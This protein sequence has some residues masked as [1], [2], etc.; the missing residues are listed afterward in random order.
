MARKVEPTES[1]VRAAEAA[2]EEVKEGAEEPLTEDPHDDRTREQTHLSFTRMR[3]DWHGADAG[4]M[5]QIRSQ[6]DHR[7]LVNFGDAYKILND[8][9]EVVRERDC[10]EE[11]GEILVD[12]HNFPVWKRSESGRFIEDYSRLGIKQREEFL[13][14]I[15]TRLVDWEQ[16]AADAWGEAMFAKGIWEE[17]F[18]NSFF[19]ETGG[20]KTDEAMTQRGRL[21]SRDERYFALYLSY[22]SRRADALMKSMERL[23]MR[24]SQGLYNK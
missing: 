9:Y 2:L 1:Q 11:T 16:Q 15:S 17:Q 8:I 19:E 18:T 21:G 12:Q 6:V 14:Q 10:D 13:F 23:S 7:I 20:R 24:L 5:H 4:I 22:Y 3:T